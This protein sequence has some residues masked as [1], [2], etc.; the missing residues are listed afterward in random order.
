MCVCVCVRVC[1]Y[2][3]V[4]SHSVWVFFSLSP[5]FPKLLCFVFLSK[6]LF[7]I[8]PVFIVDN[9]VMSQLNVF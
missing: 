9:L 1:W 8:A 7:L 4:F 6:H 3:H 5:S 2:R